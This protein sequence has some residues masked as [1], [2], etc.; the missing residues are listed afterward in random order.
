MSQPPIQPRTLRGFRDQ[1]PA[2]MFRRE[3]LLRAARDTLHRYAFA[4]ISTPV[5]EYEDILLGKGGDESDRQTYRFVDHGG[6]RVGMRFDLTVPLA[7][8]A[9]QH[10][11]VLRPPM[12]LYHVG[13]VWRGEN[14]QRGRYREFTQCDF[15]ILGADSAVADAE[16]VLLVRDVFRAAGIGPIRVRL[17][18]REVLRAALA[19]LDLT[20]VET[21]VLRVIDKLDKV[22]RDRVADELR[23]TTG[24]TAGQVADLLELVGI[25]GGV[26]VFDQAAKLLGDEGRASL[27]RL[28]AV[29]RA[30]STAAAAAPA[31]AVAPAGGEGSAPAGGDP[32]D[33]D[34]LAVDLSIARGLDYYTGIVLETLYLP[35]PEI[36][37]VCSGGRY[38]RLTSVYS[39]EQMPGMGA[40]IGVDRLLDALDPPDEAADRF[41][42]APVVLPVL[43]EARLTDYLQVARRLRSAGIGAEVYPARAK[44]GAQLKYAARRGYRVAVII[45]E[46]EW[47]AGEAQVRDLDRSE[48]TVVPTA[49]LPTALASILAPAPE[50]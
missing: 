12:R 11:G 37:S 17:N 18:S 7:R 35:A 41:A 46:N 25:S 6:R 42:Q 30:A 16:I 9:A 48:S 28:E 39:K 14:T 44:L 49:E 43:D 22:G 32:D 40:S 34:W 38:D 47:Q 20:P 45:G 26:E 50:A 19:G 31:P 1:L 10:S 8:F 23:E 15:D 4:P 3:A 24:A 5:L 2:R 29:F 13:N 36:G 27:E 33:H 21:Q